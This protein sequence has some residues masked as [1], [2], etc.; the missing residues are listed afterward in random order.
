MLLLAIEL[1]ESGEHACNL[2]VVS[3]SISISISR[4]YE[5]TGHAGFSNRI[6]MILLH[7]ASDMSPS[8]LSCGYDQLCHDHLHI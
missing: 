8:S 1:F 4:I 3:V 6:P 5:K 2:L 7:G